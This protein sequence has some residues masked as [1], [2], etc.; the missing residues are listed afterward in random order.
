MAGASLNEVPS[1]H[2][3]HVKI[4]NFI[5]APSY[6]SQIDGLLDAI[7]DEARETGTEIV[8][9]Y[10]AD[11]DQEKKSILKKVGFREEARLKDS[12]KLELGEGC[13]LLVYARHLGGGGRLARA[14]SHYYGGTPTYVK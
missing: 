13:D 1:Y 3:Q 8:H 4:L 7:I 2:E 12:L 5:G 10:L 6:I 11:V 14:P 9:A